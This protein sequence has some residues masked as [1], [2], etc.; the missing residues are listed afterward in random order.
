MQV[1]A[2]CL[3]KF[4]VLFDMITVHGAAGWPG[5]VLFF[6]LASCPRLIKSWA[7]CVLFGPGNNNKGYGFGNV[8]L[9]LVCRRSSP[10]LAGKACKVLITWLQALSMRE[11]YEAEDEVDEA[12]EE[13]AEAQAQ[14]SRAAQRASGELPSDDQGMYF[15]ERTYWGMNLPL[16]LGDNPRPSQVILVF[17]LCT[18]ALC[19]QSTFS[20][21]ASQMV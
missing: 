16:K 10:H 7:P 13:A 12:A 8:Y 9:Q 1:T 18:P 21:C 20:I 17:G 15:Y 11:T 5:A 14:R 6:Y 19:P 2:G 4:D 3:L